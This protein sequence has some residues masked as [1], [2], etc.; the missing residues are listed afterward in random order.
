LAQESQFSPRADV[1]ANSSVVSS[2]SMIANPT[3]VY[4]K[5]DAEVARNFKLSPANTPDASCMA[6]WTLGN[7]FVGDDVGDP[8]ACDGAAS[9]GDDSG[10]AALLSS[11]GPGLGMCDDADG[12]PPGAETRDRK[13]RQRR[14]KAVARA[15]AEPCAWDGRFDVQAKEA[16]QALD[17]LVASKWHVSALSAGSISEDGHIFSKTHSGPRKSHSNGMTL[18]S[19]CMLFERTLRVGGIHHYRYTIVEGSVGAADG[20]GFVFDSRIRRTN[21]QRMRSVFLNK[22]GQVCIRNFDSIMKLPCSLPKLAEGVSVTLT[23]DL[24]NAAACFK[25]DDPSGKLCGNADLN[26]SS[27]LLDTAATGQQS[28]SAAMCPS[29][30]GFFCAIV[31]GNIIVSLQ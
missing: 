7:L 9:D 26:F 25:M 23:V 19:L 24:D 5:Q 31:T 17:P 29:R 22:H 8:A 16:A 6:V 28:S 14:R 27:L 20:V 30:S 13:R 3:W 18:S 11:I 15:Q 21:I 10:A 4:T 2:H 12:G 1:S